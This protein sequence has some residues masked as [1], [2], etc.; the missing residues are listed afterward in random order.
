MKYLI[1]A[2]VGIFFLAVLVWSVRRSMRGEGSCGCDC[3]DPN[4]DCCGQKASR[5]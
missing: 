5:R 3:G 4:Q 1:F 2:G